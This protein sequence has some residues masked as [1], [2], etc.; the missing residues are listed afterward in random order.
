MIQRI[1]ARVVLWLEE[2]ECGVADQAVRFGGRLM[3][4]EALNINRSPN[5]PRFLLITNLNVLSL[6]SRRTPDY[7][8]SV[9]L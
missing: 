6:S 8:N 1:C 9:L 3:P 5:A 7:N 2:G 4:T